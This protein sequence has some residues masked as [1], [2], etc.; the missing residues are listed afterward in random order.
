MTTQQAPVQFYVQSGNAH[1]A[2]MVPMASGQAPTT[3][4]AGAGGA[5]PP[6]DER[7]LLQKLQMMPAQPY[8]FGSEARA[9]AEATKAEAMKRAFGGGF[10]LGL[11]AQGVAEYQK[12]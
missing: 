3:G 5:T 7:T 1:P 6:A 2:G 4:G 9:K 8:A 12:G 11:I 10:V